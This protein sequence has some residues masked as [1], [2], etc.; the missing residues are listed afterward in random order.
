MANPYTLYGSYASYH[1]AKTRSYLR[2]KGIP[3]LEQVPGVPRFR[4]YVRKSSDNHRIPQLE[5]PSGEV[6]QDTIAI[7]DALE[8]RHPEPPAY[9]PGLHQQ[10]AARL[11]EILIDETLGRPAWHY[12]W[13]FIDENYSFV[14]REFGRSFAPYGNDQELHHFGQI[15]AERMEGKRAGLGDSP[16]LR[17]LLEDI[18]TDSLAILDAQFQQYPYLFGGLPSMADHILM[19]AMFGHLARDPVPASIMKTRAPRVYRWTEHMNAPEIR[20]PEHFDVPE[21]Y[22]AADEIP[23]GTNRFLQF[24]LGEVGEKISLSVG[25]YNEWARGQ[26]A[27][28]SGD[29]LSDEQGKHEPSVGRVTWPLRGLTQEQSVSS[30]GIWVIQRVLDWFDGLSDAD[31]ATCRSFLET[32]GG[33]GLLDL[34]IERRL[35]RDG[36]YMAF[37]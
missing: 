17:P 32:V 24:C 30:Y 12:R 6:I 3:F 29:R 36:T 37:E 25:V 11:F 23:A 27:L 7:F 4:Q 2:K 13:N 31:K 26:S 22:V 21:T 5:T 9:P 18:Y 33:A 34:T 8:P 28:Q 35:T 20:S 15:I 10:L 14:G 16:Q 19:G 1:T